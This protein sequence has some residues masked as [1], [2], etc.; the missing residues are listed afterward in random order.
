MDVARNISR[1]IC[2]LNLPSGYALCMNKMFSID[3][4]KK[5]IHKLCDVALMQGE[6][7]RVFGMDRPVFVSNC[8]VFLKTIWSSKINV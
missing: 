3:L 5:V 2:P 1:S 6:H 4:H 8:L 7:L